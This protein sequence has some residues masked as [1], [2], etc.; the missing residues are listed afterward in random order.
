MP[1]PVGIKGVAAMH[2]G[3]DLGFGLGSH[4][5]QS[6]RSGRNSVLI[7]HRRQT[8]DVDGKHMWRNGND[9]ACAAN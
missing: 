1:A 9:V 5:G 3:L 4:A 6:T 2:A 8:I 7:S